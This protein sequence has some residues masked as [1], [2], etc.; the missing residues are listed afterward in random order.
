[1]IDAGLFATGVLCLG[2]AG[3]LVCAPLGFA[4]VGAALLFD[5]WKPDR[6]PALPPPPDRRPS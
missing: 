4:L 5:Q 1:M 3:F 6:V 2:V